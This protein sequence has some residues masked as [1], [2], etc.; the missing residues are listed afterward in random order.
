VCDPNNATGNC[1]TGSCAVGSCDYSWANCNGSPYD[2]CETNVQTPQNSCGG[3]DA[4]SHCG[5]TRCG[6]PCADT[7]WTQFSSRSWY[8][9]VWYYAYADECS[10]CSA[11]VYARVTLVSPADA[12]YDLEVYR[13]CGTLY[14][15]SYNGTGQTDQV[16]IYNT[17]HALVDD[18]FYYYVYVK[19]YSGN[20]CSYWQLK[21]E[22]MTCQ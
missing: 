6:F 13:P 2:G 22:G 14:A 1:S 5:D 12:D 8:G 21:F 15:G 3:G 17:E 18:S 20:T 11:D 16:T 19:W 7:S 9:S 4:G 10:S